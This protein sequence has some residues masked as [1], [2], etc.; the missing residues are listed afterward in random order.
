LRLRA[1]ALV[2][3]GLLVY[4]TGGVAFTDVTARASCT[5]NLAVFSWCIAGNKDESASHVNVGWTLGGGAEADL[6][7]HWFARGEY[8]YTDT[9]KFNHTFFASAPIDAVSVSVD[10]KVQELTAGIGYRF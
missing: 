8:R 4:A 6:G 10:T 5:L 1:G 9:G 7:G 3:P 2:H